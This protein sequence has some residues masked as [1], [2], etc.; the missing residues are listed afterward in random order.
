[1]LA[2]LAL[3]GCTASGVDL[4]SRDI[5][6]DQNAEPAA[7]AVVAQ[8]SDV[9][10]AVGPTY[11]TL[12]VSSVFD[13]ANPMA[14]GNSAPV[15]SGS[16]FVVDGSG[17]VITAAHVAVKPGNKV[18][19]RAAN[20]R[21]YNGKVVSVL[22][23]YDMALIKL[24]G[25]TGRA[26]TPVTNQCLRKGD[27]V[28]SLGK[29]H[30]QGDTARFGALRAM[31]FGQPVRYGAFGYPDAMVLHM[32]TQHGESGGPLFD[33]S[34]HLAGMIVSTLSDET[35]RSLTMA[36]AVPASR[37]AAFYCGAASC[38]GAW[39]AIAAEAPPRCGG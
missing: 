27:V 2:A 26:V 19:A 30:A 9:V 39:R 33:N 8:R 1:M 32:N 37:I 34:G 7:G 20:G 4:E 13:P 28:F 38:N 17:Y 15:T 6:V 31:S 11:V 22:P 5:Y 25:F 12:T 21:V 14:K 23:D 29:P 16:G 18:T 10:R 3:A 24:A 36:H 35:G